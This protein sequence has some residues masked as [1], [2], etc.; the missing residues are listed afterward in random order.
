MS[1]G[2]A[3]RLFPCNII[4]KQLLPV[5]NKPMI[6]YPISMLMLAGIKDILIICKKE[7][8]N[9][10]Q[11]LLGDGKKYGIR[12]SYKIQDSP[13]GIAESFIL[14]E[15]FIGEQDVC[16]ILGD[17][18]LYGSNI[19]D[20]L[21]DGVKIVENTRKSVI[22]SY[23]VNN[24]K[25]FGVINI[26]KKNGKISSIQEKPKKPRSKLAC[27]GI[28]M[29]SSIVVDIAK[30]LTPSDRGELEITDVNKEFLKR[31][32]LELIKFGRGIQWLDAGNPASLLESSNLIESIYSQTG[33]DISNLE[34]IAYKMNFITRKQLEE[35]INLMPR[36]E[37][38]K[39]LLGILEEEDNEE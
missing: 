28:Y 29:Y 24:P 5:Y 12:F 6:H 16:L 1:G 31:N 38:K 3:T 13:N 39:Y 34:E 9:I 17:N 33:T 21:R 8:K 18:I 32:Q 14:G 27:I 19:P 15:E 10:F 30:S 11:E 36:C 20:I 37:Y 2:N 4:S 7:D 22:F 25:D 35:N 23:H 26:N